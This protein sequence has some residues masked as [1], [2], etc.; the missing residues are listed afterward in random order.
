MTHVFDADG[1]ICEAPRVWLEYAER[2][3]RD[4]VLQ[5]RKLD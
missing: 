3:F 5:V 4:R 2:P 1:H